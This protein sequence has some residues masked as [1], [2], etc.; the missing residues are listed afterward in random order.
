[1]HVDGAIHSLACIPQS[2]YKLLCVVDV[3]NLITLISLPSNDLPATY[4][5]MYD[6]FISTI[7]SSHT[8]I[9]A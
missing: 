3:L 7:P 1:M 4:E 8:L 5:L 9:S 6:G 2:K